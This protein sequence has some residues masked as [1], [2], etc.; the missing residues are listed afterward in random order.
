M[1]QRGR[2]PGEAVSIV[3]IT[4]ETTYAAVE[5]ALQTIAG[6]SHVIA[7]PVMIPMEAK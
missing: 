6:S 4:H 2:A 1:I 3:M 7:P 5:S